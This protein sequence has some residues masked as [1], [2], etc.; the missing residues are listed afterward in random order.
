MLI[1]INRSRLFLSYFERMKKKKKRLNFKTDRG[2]S[3]FN[4]SIAVTKPW[5]DYNK[6][7]AAYNNKYFFTSLLRYTRNRAC[8]YKDIPTCFPSSL[9]GQ[10][11]SRILSRIDDTSAPRNNRV[12]AELPREGRQS[13]II[14]NIGADNGSCR[15]PYIGGT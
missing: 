2:R 1:R 13:L 12:A 9:V 15:G 14:I 4:R 11:S 7:I 6:S 10:N 5:N 3:S 8:L